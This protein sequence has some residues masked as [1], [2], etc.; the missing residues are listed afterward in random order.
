[1]CDFLCRIYGDFFKCA[2]S[3]VA[4][5]ATFSNVRLPMSHIWRLF[6]DSFDFGEATSSHSFRVTTSTQQLLFRSSYFFRAAA[7]LKS[8][9]FRVVTY[10]FQIRYFFRAK[11]LPSSHF[12][13]IRSSLGQLL[14]GTSTFLVV[15]LFGIKISTKHI[16]RYFGAASTFSEEQHFGMS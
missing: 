15:D 11:L 4:Y 10:F 5:M 6:Q 1:M 9:F 3:Y 8:S 14:F 16:Y 2:T 13:R 7:F 12:L